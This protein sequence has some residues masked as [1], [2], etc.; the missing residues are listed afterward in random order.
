MNMNR[1]HAYGLTADEL[2][3]RHGI[4]RS[5]LAYNAPVKWGTPKPVTASIVVPCARPEVFAFLH[6]MGSH[7]R[8]SH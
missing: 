3:S 4:G 6:V 8:R 7:A 1:H 2:R 5:R